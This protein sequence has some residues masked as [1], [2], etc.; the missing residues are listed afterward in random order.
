MKSWLQSHQERNWIDLVGLLTLLLV[1]SLIFVSYA[2]NRPERWAALAILALLFVALEFRSAPPYESRREH[3]RLAVATIITGLLFALDANVLGIIV[4]YFVLSAHALTVLP[5]EQG[6]GWIIAFGLLTVIFLAIAYESFWLGLINGL[7][8]FGGYYFI[9]SAA[10]AQRRA[11]AA[12]AE[13][14]R[15]LTEL[16]AAHLRLQKQAAHAEELAAAE[17]RNRLARE[18]HDTLGHRLTVAAVQLEAAQRLVDQDPAKATKM[19]AT[20]RTEVN[21]GLTELRQTVA[22]LRSPAADQQPLDAALAQLIDDFQVA[23]GIGTA[24]HLPDHLPHLNPTEQEC[25]FRIAQ[26]SLTN[27]QRHAG[28][29][30]VDVSLRIQPDTTSGDALRLTI[31][32]DGNGFDPDRT[33]DRAGFG[34]QGMRERAAHAGG[35]FE[36]SAGAGGGVT[37]TLTLPLHG[38]LP[39]N[40]RASA[41]TRTTLSEAS[42]S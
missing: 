3:I 39:D 8:A 13:S 33:R 9:G 18:L 37:V 22:A 4:I 17:E 14:Q 35:D 2:A 31:S 26:E 19:I 29:R 6:M 27:V 20:V 38:A 12:D 36:I 11:E 41:P 30:S 42:L 34:L 7:G 5:R 10:N 40:A 21:D 23:T 1:T 28:A 24:L 16:R 15:L 25:V 32:D